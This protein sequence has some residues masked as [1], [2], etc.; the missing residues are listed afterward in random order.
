[1]KEKFVDHDFKRPTMETL[2]HI[3]A[4][5]AKYESQGYDLSL[6]QLYYRLVAQDL[7]ANSQESYD[8][9]GRIVNDA[10]MA[11]IIDWQTIVDRGRETSANIHDESPRA[12]FLGAARWFSISKWENQPYHIEVMCEKDALSGI[13]EPVCRKLDVPYTPNKG[14]SSSS[15]M[16]QIA[17][18][19]E[20]A[21]EAGKEIKIL[22]LGDH[23]PSGIDMS[24]DV[25]ERLDMFSWGSHDNY[26]L[27]L[28]F[29]QVQLWNPP[30]NYVKEK[31][32]RSPDYVRKYGTDCWELDAV[33]PAILDRLITEKVEEF[34]DE[35]LLEET[36]EREKEI[37][38]KMMSYASRWKE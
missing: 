25:E 30:A 37:S 34:I 22:Y 5:I 1:M 15:M 23:D 21:E 4:V 3:L 36:K 35:E 2:N 9:I 18:R 24:R 8:R 10:R 33:E 6:R 38:R 20:I 28:N 26:R 12:A 29:E 11:G 13:I 27:A 7:I 19:L 14:Y 31:D 17:K 32:S 16:Y